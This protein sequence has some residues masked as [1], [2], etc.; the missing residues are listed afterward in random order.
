MI[1]RVFSDHQ[2]KPRQITTDHVVEH[3][4]ARMALD[5]LKQKSRVFCQAN[6]I[7]D[8]GSF[9]VRADLGGDTLELAHRFSPFEPSVKLTGIAAVTTRALCRLL[10]SGGVT[11][12]LH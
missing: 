4:V 7:S 10:Y 6:Q 12:R 8:V 5:V 11:A 1:D 9:E 3:F 2:A